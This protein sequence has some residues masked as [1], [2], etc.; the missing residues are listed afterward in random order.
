MDIEPTRVDLLAQKLELSVPF[1]TID[2]HHALP[3]QRAAVSQLPI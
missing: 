3:Q 2:A 1:E